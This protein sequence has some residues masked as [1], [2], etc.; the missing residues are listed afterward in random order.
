MPI[1]APSRAR[2]AKTQRT[3]IHSG[4]VPLHRQVRR[5]RATIALYHYLE[6]VLI[7]R[8]SK[9]DLEPRP[10]TTLW[11]WLNSLKIGQSQTSKRRSVAD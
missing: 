8:A 9:Q 6:C 11:R 7:W 10:C 3:H 4:L 1:T 2:F 5:L